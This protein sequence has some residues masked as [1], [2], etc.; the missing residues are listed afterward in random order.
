MPDPAPAPASTPTRSVPDGVLYRRLLAEA[1]PS[2]RHLAGLFLVQLLATPI[3]LLAP[4]PL[5]LA[6]DQVLGQ[7]PLPGWLD[8]VVPAGWRGPDALLAVAAGIVVVAA[9][10]AQLQD[11]GA[12]V[13]RTWL[14]ERLVL[15]LRGRLFLHL[16]RLSLVH[17]DAGTSAES[18][19]R[20]QTDAGA[21]ETVVVQG[22]VRIVTVAFRVVVLVVV[23][24]RIDAKLVLVA[25]LAGPVMVL[26][27]RRYRGRLRARWKEAKA[28]ETAA[29]GVVQETMAAMRVVKAF[30]REEHERDRW[31]ARA[32][33]GVAATMRATTYRGWFDVLMGVTA[34]LA[35]A[36]V[37]WVGVHEA[38]AGAVTL[39]QLLLVVGYLSQLF[40]PMRELGNKMAD[41]QRALAGAERVFAVLDT[42]PEVVDAPGARAL[43]RAKGEVEV[44]GVT[45]A[46]GDGR[47][48]LRDVS[49]R[50]P[51]GA[52]VGISGR[53]G[54][55]KS[56]LL[57]LLFR[58]YDP[59]EGTILL[60]GVDT[61][62]LRLADLR[63][64][65]A[66]VLQDTV[67]FSASVAENI[68]YGRPGATAAEI[69]AAARAADAHDFVT[70]LPRGYDTQVG[71]RGVRLSG[72][73]RQRIALAR[74]FL[75]DAPVLVLDEPTSA[76]DVATE[77]SVMAAIERLMRGR[78]T[79]LV[80]HR[81]STLAGCDLRLHLEDGRL[82]LASDA[83]AGLAP[84]APTPPA[85]TTSST[86]SF[87]TD[88]TDPG[89]A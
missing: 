87:A 18:V 20:V 68:A 50:V 63:R 56:T 47:P 23:A 17:H 38:R 86:T 11:M 79:F 34:G 36:A 57:A 35:G 19:Y 73:E 5:Q 72:G 30:G 1:R 8:A 33:A 28:E 69:E 66:L 81:A 64:Q 26:L 54:S 27:A 29:M 44:R 89:P 43:A 3:A 71:E 70:R 83:V 84:G 65:L 22:L 48:V 37:L 49:F 67:L 21:I 55:G 25:L 80:A 60:D 32:D 39:G 31:R 88:A 45:F 78:T 53:T 42:E 51:A 58:F 4:V 9:L 74:A 6:V 77:S 40:G 10:F 41:L 14:G 24:A 85:S 2:W 61:R 16:Q 52:R 59:G 12:W 75:K 15:A 46:Y 76:L 62:T 82:S 13:Y 7:L